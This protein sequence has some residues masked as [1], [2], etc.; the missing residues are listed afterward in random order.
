[1]ATD[2]YTGKH[3]SFT[4]FK[5]PEE[6]MVQILIGKPGLGCLYTSISVKRLME[7][8]KKAVKLP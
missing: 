8:A 5:G 7:I 6:P 4:R 2:L 3:I 1:M